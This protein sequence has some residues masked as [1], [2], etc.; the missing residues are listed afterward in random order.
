MIKAEAV[1][2]ASATAVFLGG[3]VAALLVGPDEEGPREGVPPLPVP[4][5]TA[6]STASST[7]SVSP[8][9]SAGPAIPTLGPTRATSLARGS[10]AVVVTVHVSGAT[11]VVLLDGAR[12]VPLRLVGSTASATV[13]VDCAGAP[14]AWRV[15]LTAADGTVTTAALPSPAR[16]YAQACA[17]PLPAG[18]VPTASVGS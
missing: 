15:E 6:S 5:V 1:L 7:A 2:L 8:S 4:T 14:P 9:A 13:A 17:A 11:A 16:A 18:P 3:V 10:H 12:R